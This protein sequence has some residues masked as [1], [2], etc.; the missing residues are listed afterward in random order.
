M[1]VDAAALP[2]IPAQHN[3]VVPAVAPVYKVSGVS[4]EKEGKKTHDNRISADNRTP[5]IIKPIE[6]AEVPADQCTILY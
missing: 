3:Q 5:L 4:A 1:V 6:A 2:R